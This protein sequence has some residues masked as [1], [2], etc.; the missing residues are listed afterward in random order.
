MDPVLHN[1]A[2]TQWLTGKPHHFRRGIEGQDVVEK[3][4]SA[5]RG[6]QDKPV[7]N[8]VVQSVAMSEHSRNT[9]VIRT[10]N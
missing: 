10:Q 4:V 8:V 6:K 2:P 3:I 7:K 1:V 5:P 9:I